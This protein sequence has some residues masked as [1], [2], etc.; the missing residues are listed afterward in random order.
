MNIIVDL[1]KISQTASNKIDFSTVIFKIELTQKVDIDHSKDLWIFLKTLI[2]G[3]AQKIFVDM[4]NLGYIDSSGIGVLINAAKLARKQKGDIIL[5][6][7]SDEVK[8]IFKVI[9]LENF[10]KIYNSEVDAINSYRYL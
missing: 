6:N 5:A 2:S 3:G 1:L 7:V 10:I 9:N 8:G 4:K